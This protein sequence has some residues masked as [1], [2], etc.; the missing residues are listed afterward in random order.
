MKKRK[1]SFTLFNPLTVV[2]GAVLSLVGVYYSL[3]LL[4]LLLS[5]G[6]AYFLLRPLL[7]STTFDTVFARLIASLMLYVVILQAVVLTSWL[8]DHNM[9]LR[10]V[11]DITLVILYVSLIWRW[12]TEKKWYM[13][14]SDESGSRIIGR[15]DVICITVALGL[16][17]LVFLGPIIKNDKLSS[18]VALNYINTS[19]DDSNHLSR[20]NDRLQLDRGVLANTDKVE[21]VVLAESISSYP[22]GWHSANAIIIDSL[23]PNIKVGSHT[24]VAYVISKA[25]WLFVLAY[26]FCKAI[27]H[28]YRKYINESFTGYGLVTITWLTGAAAFF[29]YYAL[30][31]QF[32]EG[33]Y[34]F[35]P[36][37]I[38]LL[39]AML[40]F[41]QKE[42][43]SERSSGRTFVALMLT[44]VGIT[45]SWILALPAISLAILVTYLLSSNIR[46][47]GKNI[48]RVST[49][50]GHFLPLLL[51][52][53]AAI[54]VQIYLIVTTD[55]RSFSE[56]VNDPGAISLHSDWYYVFLV[57][58]IAAFY[59]LAI[60]RASYLNGVTVFLLGLLG[61]SLFIFLFQMYSIG[62]I[63][64][65][66]LKTIN[67]FVVVSLPLAIVG[68]YALLERASQ[69]YSRLTQIAITLLTL[70]SLP[71]I[72]GVNPTNTSNLAYLVGRRDLSSSEI[73]YIHH[74]LDER[75]KVPVEHR[76]QD[77][78]FYTPGRVG[79][80]IVASNI[81]R[82]IQHID[83][84][85][86]KAFSALLQDSPDA[87]VKSVSTCGIKE[88]ELTVVTQK[89]YYEAVKSL[90][91]NPS[92]AEK[93][94]IVALD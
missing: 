56:A 14:L 45:L 71:I 22:P 38:F 73:T 72:I 74:S 19:L 47:V 81:L 13:D 36:Q 52:S 90:F 70:F 21:Y 87:L 64:Y 39:L 1:D 6:A 15:I 11:L 7:Y 61:F 78:I 43:T 58:G 66:S 20:I 35:I 30:L 83:T 2:I 68:I 10:A 50:L 4:V 3:N 46:V 85:D 59:R 31:E 48:T 37:L 69:G 77:V 57:V 60:A 32:R 33:F 28:F 63:E 49:Q 5:L 75:S 16:I 76:T 25:F 94:R 62:K 23:W 91:S 29:A 89:K 93:V 18:E 44:T 41:T 34:S 8:I 53:V 42:L 80:N 40:L 88:R 55:Y 27:F 84:C 26:L 65:Y 24:V 54:F 67:T 92:F 86:D 79:H 51:I 9:S 12:F 17:L 82:S